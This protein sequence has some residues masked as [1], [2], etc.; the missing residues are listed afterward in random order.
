ME[1][2]CSCKGCWMGISSPMP[3]SVGPP[4]KHARSLGGNRLFSWKVILAKILMTFQV[5]LNVT[6]QPELKKEDI[7]H[8]CVPNLFPIYSTVFSEIKKRL[9]PAELAGDADECLEGIRVNPFLLLI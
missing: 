4:L 7:H 3:N 5:L 1:I 6:W 9:N 2:L 8:C